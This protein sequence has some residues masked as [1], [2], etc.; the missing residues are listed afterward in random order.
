MR[1]DELLKQELPKVLSE[2]IE[3]MLKIKANSDEKDKHLKMHEIQE[4]IEEELVKYGQIAKN[5]ADDRTP[6]W[7]A[8]DGVFLRILSVI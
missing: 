4:Y 6:D 3:E 7:T 8:L 2:E 5:R 1:F